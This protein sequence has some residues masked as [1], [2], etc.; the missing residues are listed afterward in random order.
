MLNKDGLLGN[1]GVQVVIAMVVGT[2][3]GAMMGEGAVVFAPLGAI[4][5][6]LIKMLVIP[7]VAVALISGA[8]GL[9]NSSNAG[10]VGF[11]TLGYFGLTSALAVALALVMGAVFQPGVGIDVSGVEG[12][13]SAEYASKGELPTFWATITGMIPENVFQ[14]LNE[15]NILQILVFCLFFG[16]AL[17]KQSKERREPIVNGVNTIVD[18]MVWMINKVMIIAPIGVFGLMA[19]AVGT[20]G[21]GALM[22]VFKLFLVYVAAILVFGFIVYPLMIQ[23]FTKTSAKK[24]LSVMKKPQAVALS[25]SSSMAT[26]PVTMN[27]VENELGVK[28]ST[29]SFVL[30][31]GA[32]INMSGN[33]IYYGLVAIFF[34]Q[35]FNIDLSMGA[36]IAIILTSTLGAVGQAGVP[37]PSFLVVAVLLAAGIP[38]EGLPLLFALDRIFDMIRTA[39]NI[40]G[41]AA[42]AVIVDSLV[43]EEDFE[44]QA[45]LEKQQA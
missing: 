7:L 10:K 31:L 9:G 42:C 11:V 4:F 20:F 24:F 18:S 27:T 23:V 6:N 30:P 17:S 32:T 5:I 3:V 21:F 43:E 26:L 22:V 19:E 1:L 33:A 25:T 29:A 12:M 2:L 34:A 8:A 13:F 39:L 40:T 37:G 14:S 41:D 36:Y 45:E 44:A 15:A 38:I 35:L 16:I 28:N